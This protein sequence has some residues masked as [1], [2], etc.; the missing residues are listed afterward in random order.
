MA[1]CEKLS[2][3]KSIIDDE[4]VS[5]NLFFIT[6]ELKEGVAKSAKI[7]DKYR[8][9]AWSVDVAPELV[10]FFVGVVQKQVSKALESEDYELE[11]YDVISDDLSNRLYTYALN[12]ALS[13]SDVVTTF[14]SRS[15]LYAK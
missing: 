10:S 9:R 3:T 12:N 6:R 4:A 5:V 13:F 8:F 7:I 11:P 14:S 15:V 2:E 1:A